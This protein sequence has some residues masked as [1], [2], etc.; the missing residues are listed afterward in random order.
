MHTIQYTF[1]GYKNIIHE[2]SCSL[3]TCK[4]KMYLKKQLTKNRH[5]DGE[6]KNNHGIKV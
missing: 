3:H 1:I 6:A 2:K 4:V 5:D